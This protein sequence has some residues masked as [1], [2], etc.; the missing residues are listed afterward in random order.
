MSSNP[1]LPPKAALER[2][3][4]G[5]VWRD[6]KHVV[7]RAGAVL[8][9]RCVKCNEPA[10][11]PMEPRKL[12]WHH[13]ALFLLILVN[14]LIY[15]VVALLA[16]KRA[17]VTFGLCA[18]HRLRRRV[19]L[20][21]GWGGFALGVLLMFAGLQFAAIGI[22]LVLASF[23]A[24]AIGA[25][26][27][28]AA[29]ISKTE[30]RLA[31]CGAPFVDSIEANAPLSRTGYIPAPGDEHKLG[32]CPNCEAVIPLDTQECPECN[33]LFGTGSEWKVEPLRP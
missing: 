13:P 12:S 16:R 22:L 10:L 28:Y 23:L 33:A 7:V 24:G 5:E 32:S 1:Y 31:G 19:F 9:P 27:A 30:V 2:R 4:A 26:T 11:Q 25:R 8:P 18:R 21:I 3:V 6:G 20:A 15:V 14:I 29:R 17:E